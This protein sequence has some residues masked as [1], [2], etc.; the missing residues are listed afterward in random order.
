MPLKAPEILGAIKKNIGAGDPN[1]PLPDMPQAA[2]EAA[3]EPE[4]EVAAEPDAP[5]ENTA[6]DTAS[7][8]LLR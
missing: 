2:P 5:E 8:E 4:P 3:P 7:D 1:A 6:L